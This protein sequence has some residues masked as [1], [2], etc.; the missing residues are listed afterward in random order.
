MSDRG[1][2]PRNYN[3]QSTLKAKSILMLCNKSRTL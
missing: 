3:A 2:D 1:V